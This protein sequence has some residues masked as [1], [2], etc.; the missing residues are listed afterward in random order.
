VRALPARNF[1]FLHTNHVHA[2]M[3]LRTVFASTATALA[4][5]AGAPAAGQLRPLDPVEWRMFE[6]ARTV[7]VEAGVGLY[8]D[9]RAALAGTVG[10]LIEAGE[11]RAFWRT[12]RVVF[13]GSGTVYRIFRD[14]RVFAAPD[15]HVTHPGGRR[16]DSG[17]YRVV[18][19]VRLTPEGAP[20]LGVLRFGT[21]L[22]TTDNRVGLERDMTDF[23]ALAGASVRRGS[24]LLGGE[25]GV[26]INGT[27]DPEFE[28]KDVL[29]YILRAE[30]QAG[31][32]VPSL[33]VT[34]DVLG[35]Q[36]RQLRGNERLGEA[37]LGLRAGGRRWL[38]AEAVAGYE[39]FSPRVGLRVAAG[40]DW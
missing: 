38:R 10:R 15:Q 21:R 3:H 20:V 18:S 13:E 19:T 28:Q 25:A 26:S 17:D 32:V 36:H 12:G 22:P 6:P 40:M 31:P 24:L 29:V 33:T 34:G 7:T 5:L 35:P 37:R 2:V 9:Q 11:F 16:S 1:S 39:T 27:R 23:F 14:E 30:Y 4:T 8:A